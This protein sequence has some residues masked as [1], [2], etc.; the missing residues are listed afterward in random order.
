MGVKL[1]AFLG[2]GNYDET[3]YFFADE[4]NG[5]NHKTKF[6]QEAIIKILEIPELEV[7]VFTTDK[8]YEKNW[9]PK[10]EGLRSRLENINA[11]FKNIMIPSGASNDEIWQIFNIVYENIEENDEIYVDI[12]HSFRSIPIVF[13][14]VL[15]HAKI[16]KGCHVK[17]ILYGAFE[18][19]TDN[20]RTPIFDLTL[21][22][23]ITDWSLGVDQLIST[24]ES[25][26]FCLAAKETINPL[27]AQTK[28]KDE[29]IKL[30]AKC[31]KTI[32]D[33]YTD[34]KLSQGQS[35]Q[36]SG[37]ELKKVLS[38]IKELNKE[39]R[40]EIK[41]FYNILKKIEN[42]VSF[43]E[44]DNLVKNTL[45]CAKLCVKFGQYQ[46]AYTFLL[47]NTINYFCIKAELDWRDLGDRRKVEK[48]ISGK[49]PIIENKKTYGVGDKSKAKIKELQH[50]KDKLEF[51]TE[52][53][54]KY[55][56]NLGQYRNTLNHAE[57]RKNTPA[58]KKIQDEIN[59][60]IGEFEKIFLEEGEQDHVL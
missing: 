36:K 43:F 26:K 17:R 49:N 30:T 32:S 16:T 6:T 56:Y 52:D 59:S 8:A 28:G 34:L 42:Q 18:S 55:H 27:K 53:M 10:D 9:V 57:F 21:F 39:E 22:D 1:F 54:T 13:M 29:L 7:I 41:P 44:E 40:L 38:E 11:K 15:N 3:E 51:M 37:V 14:S 48:I 50:L 4:S 35:I 23:K 2:T 60:F 19:K 24:G 47:E 5:K 45:E 20:N 31:A 46:Q 25:A 33:F 12:T 58:K